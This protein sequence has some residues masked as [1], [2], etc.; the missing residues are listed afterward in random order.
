MRL[1]VIEKKTAK[2]YDGTIPGNETN[3]RDMGSRVDQNHDE[4]GHE[5]SEEDAL[6]PK[7]EDE[8]YK[9]HYEPNRLIRA[10]PILACFRSP[11]LLMG[12]G[13]AFVQ[14]A[15]L[16]V[17]DATI[18]TETQSLFQFSPLKA[19]L[20]FIALDVPYLLLG[21][22]AVGLLIVMERNLRR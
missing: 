4:A 11:R 10:L 2:K 13:L 15:L 7:K 9:I 16:A 19:G 12:L 20:I 6:L 22:I 3:P 21:P 17:Y 18:T 8:A 14:A 5:A 1:L